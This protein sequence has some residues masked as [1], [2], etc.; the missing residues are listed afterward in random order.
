[1][2]VGFIDIDGDKFL[3]VVC[4]WNIISWNGGE[5]VVY[6]DEEGEFVGELDVMICFFII[7]D[8]FWVG[9]VDEVI[10]LKMVKVMMDFN[11][12]V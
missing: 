5:V 8:D 2:I 11:N 6:I 4:F 12:W 9:L 1:M 7:G 3:D 10:L